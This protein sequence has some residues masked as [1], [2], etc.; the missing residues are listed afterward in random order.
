MFEKI[1]MITA[2]VGSG[3]AI[4]LLAY[5]ALEVWWRVYRQITGLEKLRA[6]KRAYYAKG[7]QDEQR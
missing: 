4:G 2:L 7:P 3:L 1:G 5:A 6:W